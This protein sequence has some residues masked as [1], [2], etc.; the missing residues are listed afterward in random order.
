MKS[1][2]L[3]EDL[4]TILANLKN[5]ISIEKSDRNGATIEIVN[6][7]PQSFETYIYKKKV[8]DRDADFEKLQALIKEHKEKV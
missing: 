6:K 5:I 8:A 2:S 7:E 4:K 1:D 3:N